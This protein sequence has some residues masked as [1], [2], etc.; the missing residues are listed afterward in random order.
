ML[1][2]PSRGRPRRSPDQEAQVRARVTQIAAQLLREGG[3][4]ALSMRRL[5]READIPVMS[6]YDYFRS[7]NEVI[8]SMW[9]RFFAK[10]FDRVDRAT[11]TCD[12]NARERLEV[13]CMAYVRYWLEHRDEYRAVFMIEDAIESRE[14]YYVETSTILERYAVFRELLAEHLGAVD[15]TSERLRERTVAL[16]CALAGLCHM[17]VTV[18]EHSWPAPDRLLR[19]ALRMVDGPLED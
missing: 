6:L 19:Q 10:C 16:I 12:G 15:M 3:I 13:A 4:S 18:S 17:L 7:K 8:R 2:R 11:S 14:K 9:D 5:A 1:A